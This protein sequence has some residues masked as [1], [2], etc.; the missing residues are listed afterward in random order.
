MFLTLPFF[1]CWLIIFY[2]AI[3][4]LCFGFGLSTK[5]NMFPI[6]VVSLPLAILSIYCGYALA[7]HFWHYPEFWKIVL[8]G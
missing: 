2:C 6:A 3:I 7:K 5:T 8:S 4:C 1:F